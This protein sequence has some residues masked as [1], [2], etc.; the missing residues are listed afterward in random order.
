[1]PETGRVLVVGADGLVGATVAARLEAAGTSV[2]RTSRRGSPGSMPLDMSAL[3]TQWSP[4]PGVAAAVLCAAVTSTEACRDRPD[5]ARRVNV[6]GTLELARRLAD[7][8][9]RI[10]FL[11]TNLV[12]DGSTPFTPATAARCPRTAY[13]RMKAEAEERLLALGGTTVVRLTKVVGRTLPVIDRWRDSLD[14]GEPIRPLTD[15]VVAPVSLDLAAMVIAATARE[16]LGPI[17]QVSARAD[18]TYADVAARLAA[19]WGAA[20]A[21]VQPASAADLGLALEHLPAHT[22]LDASLVRDRLGIEPPDPWAALD[23]CS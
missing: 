6:E 2:I 1:M 14:R 20:S 18:V 7:A 17:L 4:P 3:S 23:L 19:R 21:L 13:G 10:V 11:S 12:F 5:E 22:T 15:L 9:A 8:G 16:P